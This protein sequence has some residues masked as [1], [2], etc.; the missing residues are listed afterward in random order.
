MANEDIK[1][2]AKRVGVQQWKIADAL[3]I[4]E[5]TFCRKLRREL[6]QEAKEKIF[7]IIS[8]LAKEVD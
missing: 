1:V 7:L 8:E 2:A 6:P 5:T 3:G 4:A